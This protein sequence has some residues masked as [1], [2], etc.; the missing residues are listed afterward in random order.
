MGTPSLRFPAHASSIPWQGQ[1]PGEP[2][3]AGG[4]PAHGPSPLTQVP[5][6]VAVPCPSWE[7]R[8]PR[9]LSAARLPPN[10]TRPRA[11]IQERTRALA[12]LISILRS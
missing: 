8:G 9:N 11:R 2:I 12:E 10:L 5:G 3:T 7:Q 1:G 6:L 4:G